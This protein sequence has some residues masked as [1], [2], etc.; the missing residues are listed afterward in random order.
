MKS[1]R[2]RRALNR[3]VFG[4]GCLSV[5]L[6]M[7]VPAL[8]VTWQNGGDSLWSNVNN[9]DT[10]SVP[11]SG[12]TVTFAAAGSTSVDLGGAAAICSSLSLQRVLR[13]TH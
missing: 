3:L 7:L 9:W 6:W 10:L 12:S 11:T 1:I 4:I 5:P 2:T 13:L 8:A